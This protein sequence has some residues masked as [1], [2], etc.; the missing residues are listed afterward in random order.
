ME[1]YKPAPF[2]T[3][4]TLSAHKVYADTR[5]LKDSYPERETIP[6]SQH[7]SGTFS[8][9]FSGTSSSGTSGSK[10]QKSDPDHREKM[11]R[12]LSFGDARVFFPESFV[13]PRQRPS[14]VVIKGGYSMREYFGLSGVLLDFSVTALG[15]SAVEFLSSKRYKKM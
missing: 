2:S 6:R 14:E 3:S 10:A 5:R 4:G 1:I 7:N 13:I 8:G 9:T 11:N 12:P 15:P